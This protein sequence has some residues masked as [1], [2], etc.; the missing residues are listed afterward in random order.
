MA[1]YVSP[2]E[3]RKEEIRC[4][5]VSRSDVCGWRWQ[6]N[7]RECVEATLEHLMWLLYPKFAHCTF[8]ILAFRIVKWRSVGRG[9][10]LAN[11]Q[12]LLAFL[13]LV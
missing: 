10:T 8:T 13:W 7:R 9:M 3:G 5:L 4:D 2:L 12:A 1:G 6:M 11:S